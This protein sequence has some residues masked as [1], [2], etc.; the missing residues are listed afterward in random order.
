LKLV[1][2]DPERRLADRLHPPGL[3]PRFDDRDPARWRFLLNNITGLLAVTNQQLTAS[4]DFSLRRVG[5]LRHRFDFVGQYAPDGYELGSTWSYGWGDEVTPL[6]LAQRTGLGL[7]GDMLRVSR[8]IGHPGYEVS[9]TA[10]HVYDTRPS[11]I[12]AYEGKGLSMRLVLARG[13]DRDGRSYTYARASASALGIVP[14]SGYHALVGRVRGDAL[15]GDPPAQQDLRLGGRYT[16]GRGYEVDEGFGRRRL[17]ASVED[18]HAWSVNTRSDLFGLMML[19]GVEGAVFADAVYM[20]LSTPACGRDVFF[21]VGYGLRFLVDVLNVSPSSIAVD[22]GVP[23]NRCAAAG[24]RA[25]VTVYLA[26]V[27]SFLV[28]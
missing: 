23:L 28:F 25:P 7:T 11:L 1:E 14:L 22:V 5:D 19:T 2:L 12:S 21:D 24:D 9:A 10:F 6:R 15:V 8:G 13:A 26:F 4:A 17:V 20:P 3:D 16:T 27:Q 18:R